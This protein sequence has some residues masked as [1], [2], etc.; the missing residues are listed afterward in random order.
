MFRISIKLVDYEYQGQS[1][2]IGPDTSTP[3]AFFY[4]SNFAT[5]VSAPVS[6]ERGACHEVCVNGQNMV[7]LPKEQRWPLHERAKRRI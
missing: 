7:E 3:K 1:L 5:A 6:P 4:V 2:L